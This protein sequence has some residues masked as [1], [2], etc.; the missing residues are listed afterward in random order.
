MI[1]ETG[2]GKDGISSTRFQSSYDREGLG[3]CFESIDSRRSVK[4]LTLVS[5]GSVSR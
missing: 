1:C 2:A 4:L 5:G 3:D